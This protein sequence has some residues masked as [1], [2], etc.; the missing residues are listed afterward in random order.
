MKRK[1]ILI[2]TALFLMFFSIGDSNIVHA[3]EYFDS[4]VNY[5]ESTDEIINPDRG[6]YK[7]VA[8]SIDPYSSTPWFEEYTFDKFQ[9]SHGVFHLRIGLEHFSKNA[10]YED[11][12]IT[13]EAKD[14]LNTVLSYI[15]GTNSSAIIRFSYDVYG[16][17]VD[18]K[19]KNNEPSMDLIEQHI[20]SLGT[21]INQN[22]DVICGVETGMLGPWGE[23]HGT[24][25]AKSSSAY[26]RLVEA[27]LKAVDKSRGVTVRTPDHFISW[28]NKRYNLS[29]DE[30]NLGSFKGI[31]DADYPRVGLFNDGYLGSESDLGTYNNRDSGIAFL[32][33]QA[34]TTLYGGEVVKAYEGSSGE[35]LSVIGSYNS[36]GHISKE[37]FITHT[38]Y[39]NID[40][41]NQVI[42]SWK[43]DTY[44]GDD[45]VYKGKSGFEYVSNHLGYR[46]VIRNLQ[47]TNGIVN[48]SFKVKGQIENVGFGNVVNK[49]DTYVVLYDD[50]HTYK[51]KV[52]FDITKVLASSS[53]SFEFEIPLDTSIN[54]G[55]YNLGIQIKDCKASDDSNKRC[56][57]FANKNLEYDEELGV[58]KVSSIE[59]LNEGE[60]ATGND[61]VY[62]T[63]EFDIGDAKLVSGELI[64][65]VKEGNG[66]L[67]PKVEKDGYNFLGYDAD[68][69]Y[70]TGDMVIHPI[71]EA[72]K[73]TVEF[74]SKY[75]ASWESGEKIQYVGYG[76]DAIAPIVSRVGF[77]FMGWDKDFTN[78]KDDIEVFAIW[79]REKKEDTNTSTSD[80]EITTED[81]SLVEEES[82]IVSNSTADEDDDED[83]GYLIVNFG[84]EGSVSGILPIGLM[85]IIVLLFK[86]RRLPK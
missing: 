3:E 59:I 4:G 77:E 7:A 17:Q 55:R 53:K 16:T 79:Q 33:K 39:L 32:Q 43:T 40:W 41:N 70:V 44:D 61:D 20:A 27:W 67:A 13:T 62:Y 30:D 35:S 18:G 1:L 48:K 57:R 86:R 68:F 84:C 46:L 26:Y 11:L 49:K 83:D 78:V 45:Q 60:I 85:G 42:A 38:S 2:I 14:A 64:Q 23:Q 28:A 36:I 72:R 71:F 76:E 5:Q 21:V 34:Q 81:N 50:E 47:L 82:T 65:Q 25:L 31:D 63:V 10:G 9:E 8:A 80:S 19:Y 51:T 58:N 75:P 22:L 29:L 66:A 73:Y 54:V 69:D 15:R 52:D 37:G 56:I 24:K 12:Q 74:K 6:F